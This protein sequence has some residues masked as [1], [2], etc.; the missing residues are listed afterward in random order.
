MHFHIKEYH[1]SITLIK[2]TGPLESIKIV[3]DSDIS[4]GSKNPLIDDSLFSLV[5]LKTMAVYTSNGN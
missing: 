4:S 2:K 1:S 5:L 3:V